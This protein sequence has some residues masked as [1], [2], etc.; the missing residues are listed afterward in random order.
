[1]LLPHWTLWMPCAFTFWQNMVLILCKW[2]VHRDLPTLY[3]YRWRANPLPL[4]EMTQPETEDQTP[5]WPVPEPKGQSSRSTIA[6]HWCTWGRQ[7]VWT[8]LQNS[9]LK[10][11]DNNA[12]AS[13][14]AWKKHGTGNEELQPVWPNNGRQPE[15]IESLRAGFPLQER[16]LS[17]K[18]S[19]VR[20]DKSRTALCS[21]QAIIVCLVQLHLK[22]QR[23]SAMG[24]L[25]TAFTPTHHEPAA[26]EAAQPPCSLLLTL[27]PSS[28]QTQNHPSVLH[29]GPLWFLISLTL[30]L[31]SVPSPRSDLPSAH[32]LRLS[33]SRK[34]VFLPG[35]EGSKLKLNRTADETGRK[36]CPLSSACTAKDRELYL[37][38]PA[39]SVPCPPHAYLPQQRKECVCVHIRVCEA[40]PECLRIE[41]GGRS[42]LTG[43]R[44]SLGWGAGRLLYGVMVLWLV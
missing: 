22:W 40:G 29:E 42:L 38:R 16:A 27:T 7:S 8:Y 41:L 6:W 30:L 2:F 20:L 24:G 39:V 18:H 19:H 21:S 43:L 11:G 9:T 5:W 32:C 13:L 15:P 17:P 36:L 28:C 3:I 31:L 4:L 34:I 25:K 35:L 33:L 14:F 10:I 23:P 44:V 37:Y 1:M 26:R 12:R